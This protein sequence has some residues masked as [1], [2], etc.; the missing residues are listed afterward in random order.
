M[1]L[2]EYETHGNVAVVTLNRP[3]ARNAINPEVAIRLAAM[4]DRIIGCF[5]P[6]FHRCFELAVIETSADTSPQSRVRLL[7][8]CLPE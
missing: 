8:D 7:R 2:V 5:R 1:K 6:D 4:H 3:E